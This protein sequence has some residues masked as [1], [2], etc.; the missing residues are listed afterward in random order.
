MS[1]KKSL[2]L[3]LKREYWEAIRDG[4]KLEEYRERVPYWEKRIPGKEFSDVV[5]LCGF[6]KAGDESRTLRRKWNGYTE[7]VI[8]HPHFGDSVEV[9]AIDVSE[10]INN[11]NP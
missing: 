3:H 10:H 6:P 5:L 9:F 2:I 4:S 11:D 7:K 8:T 1:V